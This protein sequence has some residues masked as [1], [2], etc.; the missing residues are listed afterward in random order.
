MAS[1]LKTGNSGTQGGLAQVR[2]NH[3]RILAENR[4]FSLNPARA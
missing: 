4:G 2:A 3:Q 1:Q